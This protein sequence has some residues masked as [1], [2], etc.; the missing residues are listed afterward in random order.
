M[1]KLCVE[2]EIEIEIE[3]ILDESKVYYYENWKRRRVR[4]EGKMDEWMDG[5]MDG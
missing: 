5:W 1:K 3:I 4:V 2:P